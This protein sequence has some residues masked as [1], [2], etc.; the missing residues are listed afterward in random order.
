[1][2]DIKLPALKTTKEPEQAP[3]PRNKNKKTI[4]LMSDD[5]RMTSGV[6]VMSLEIIRQTCH[7]Y[8]WVQI[9]GAIKHPE[10][11][12][13][14]DCSDDLSEYTG[15]KDA[16]LLIYPTSGYGNDEMVRHLMVNHNVAAIMIYTDPRFWKWLFDM[17]HEIR[18]QIPIFYYN[19]WDDLPF[20][21]WNE[22]FYESVDLTLN[23]TKQTWNIVRNVRT[24]V[25][26]KD[27]E[28]TLT[29]HGINEDVFF[30][31]TKGHEKWDEF[32][33][34]NDT[35]LMNKNTNFVVL[36]NNRNIRRKL[37]GDVILAMKHFSD[38]LEPEDRK[39][40]LLIMKTTPV[41]NN[42]TDLIAVLK[43]MAPELNVLFFAERNSEE[44]MNYIY[45]MSDVCINIASNEGFGLGT[46]EAMMAGLPIVVNVTGG[47]QDQCGFTKEDGSL[48]VKED[49]T[50]EW[51]SNHD[52]RYK[53]HGNWV[54]PV[55]PV[56][57]SLQGSPP[58]PYIFDDRPDWKEV[59]DKLKEWYD[60]P[61][62]ERTQAGLDGRDYCL[63]PETM[64]SAKNMGK[65][66]IDNM[67]R[68]WDNWKPIK[69]FEVYEV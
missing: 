27:W 23:I 7:K 16:S 55:W 6:G 61:D 42:G 49:Y 51:G 3:W 52:G 44:E 8:N 37:P 36:W 64:M 34:F 47:L 46:A 21:M 67:E 33:K 39:N 18:S 2:A 22:P 28:C 63:L 45:N 48:L 31:I 66:F 68:C 60:T 1:M 30:P 32:A 58:T 9:G 25:P 17:S 59:G 40:L 56:S 14:F 41:D 65:A 12:Q 53:D 4:M 35:N 11:G 54:K 26:V 10:E 20:P 62:E 19:I 24:H 13:V 38:Q 5:C 43:Q 15:V 29:P 50:K 69:Q 57:L